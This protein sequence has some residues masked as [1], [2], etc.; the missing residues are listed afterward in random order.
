M[1]R[2]LQEKDC[3]F[4]CAL[5]R[6]KFAKVQMDTIQQLNPRLKSMQVTPKLSL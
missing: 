3:H 5:F 6:P 1:N 4:D 2:P